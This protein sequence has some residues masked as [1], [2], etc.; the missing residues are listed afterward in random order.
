M[1]KKIVLEALLYGLDGVL[2]E[3]D[4]FLEE[5]MEFKSLRPVVNKII[6]TINKGHLNVKNDKK[7]INSLFPYLKPE[8]DNVEVKVSEDKI[9]IFKQRVQKLNLS[10]DESFSNVNLL[11]SLTRNKLRNV[12]STFKTKYNDISLVENAVLTASLTTSLYHYALDNDIKLDDYEKLLEDNAFLLVS[13]DFSGIQNFVFDIPTEGALR[14]LRSRSFYLDMIS[15]VLVD[16]ILSD[17]SLTRAQVI[18]V[19]GGHGYLLLPNTKAVKETVER[20]INI[21]NS[22]FL[23]EFDYKIYVSHAIVEANSY[24]LMSVNE[25][26]E[27]NEGFKDLMSE[28]FLNVSLD[29]RKKYNIKSLKE[30]NVTKVTDNERECSSC[31]KTNKLIKKGD[32]FICETC[33]QFHEFSRIF[34]DEDKKFYAVLDKKTNNDNP[35]IL[36]YKADENSFLYSLNEEEFNNLIKENKEDIINVY[37][38]NDNTYT[39]HNVTHLSFVDTVIKNRHDQQLSIDE[40]ANLEEGIKRIAVL[41]LDVDSLGEVFKEGFPKSM[42]NIARMASLSDKLSYFFKVEI[43]KLM[44][45]LNVSVVFSGGDDVFLFGTLNDTIKFSQRMYENF[46][47]YTYKK[48]HFSAG[49]SIFESKYPIYKISDYVEGLILSAKSIEGKNSVAI[50]DNKQIFKWEKFFNILNEEEKGSESNILKEVFNKNIVSNTMLYNSVYKSLSEL[51]NMKSPEKL[52]YKLMYLLGKLKKEKD[53]DENDPTFKE[54]SNILLN[55]ANIKQKELR[56]QLLLAVQLHLYRNR[57]K[58]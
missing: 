23:K 29:K 12:P 47:D 18:Y 39:S 8:T 30:L 3:K 25:A 22:F 53:I 14:N 44:Q 21:F 6:E 10:K 51:E 26:M 27:E 15:E 28:V 5:S 55:A 40:I 1:V 32:K 34:A 16:Q 31:G 45:G 7:Y 41:K 42:Y 19:G 43:K 48:L 13:F 20:K 37:V 24:K 57:E 58:E 50:F 11:I 9:R 33:N 4:L 54:F 2:D 36:P 38:K 17:L 56:K 35:L 52:P 49:I 46:N